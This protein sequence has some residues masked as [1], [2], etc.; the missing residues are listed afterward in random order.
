MRYFNYSFSLTF[1]DLQTHIKELGKNELDDQIPNENIKFSLSPINSRQL[2]VGLLD[3][4]TGFSNGEVLDFEPTIF[5]EYVHCSSFLDAVEQFLDTN[6]DLSIYEFFD[7]G[8]SPYNGAHAKLKARIHTLLRQRGEILQL[9]GECETNTDM[10][11]CYCRKVPAKNLFNL[12]ENCFLHGLN[13]FAASA[14][15][16]VAN[17]HAHKLLPQIT[18]RRVGQ[19]QLLQLKKI[20]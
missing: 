10:K 5:E 19:A 6:K 1:M 9:N 14:F 16:V 12:V 15:F 18:G 20:R 7:T 13:I 8:T 3:S 2:L 11:T 17:Y 4:Y